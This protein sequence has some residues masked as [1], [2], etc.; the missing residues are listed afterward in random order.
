MVCLGP[1]VSL[2]DIDGWAAGE[3][4]GTFVLPEDELLRDALEHCGSEKLQLNESRL[5]LPE[6]MM[7]DL[8]AVG[9]R[10]HRH[11]SESDCHRRNYPHADYSRQ[12]E[13][14]V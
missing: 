11:C 14:G 1:V 7:L 9:K 10:I 8:G 3:R 6:G 4:E 13:A 12:L 5:Y 2:W